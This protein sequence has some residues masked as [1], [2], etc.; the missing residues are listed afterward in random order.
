MQLI[1]QQHHDTERSGRR[2]SA[3]ETRAAGNKTGQDDGAAIHP[4]AASHPPDPLRP[5]AD[6]AVRNGFQGALDAEGRWRRRRGWRRIWRRGQTEW[7][8]TLPERVRQR[9]SLAR[10][11]SLLKL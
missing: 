4:L 10:L 1:G 2:D 11:L 3:Q 5:A 9:R 7:T 8:H 6:D